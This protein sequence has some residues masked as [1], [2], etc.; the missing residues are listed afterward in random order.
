MNSQMKTTIQSAVFALII[1]F[2]WLAFFLAGSHATLC[3]S[4]IYF[5]AFVFL[6]LLAI[7]PVS[8]PLLLLTLSATFF[9]LAHLVRLSWTYLLIAAAVAIVVIAPAAGYAVIRLG[10]NPLGLNCDLP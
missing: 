5:S 3:H 4:A 9:L 1:A 8:F 7:G 10:F 6:L 2:F